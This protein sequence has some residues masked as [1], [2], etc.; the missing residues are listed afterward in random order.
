[1]NQTVSRRAKSKLCYF[2]GTNRG[3]KDNRMIQ[4]MIRSAR[5][6]GV[7]ED[8]YVFSPEPV[9]EAMQSILIKQGYPWK[10]H[11]AKLEFLRRLASETDYDYF[12][13]LDSDN[14]FTRDPGDLANLIRGNPLWVCMEEDVLHPKRRQTDWYGIP[15]PVLVDIF[16][17]EGATCNQVWS[18]NGGFWIVRREAINVV[19][20]RA[21]D[22]FHRMHAAGWKNT[23]DELVLAMLGQTM[24]D[25]PHLNTLKA[26]QDIWACDWIGRFRGTVPGGQPWLYADWLT[27][28]EWKINPAIV[29]AMRSKDAMSGTVARKTQVRPH[30]EPVGTKLSDI[31]KECGVGRPGCGSCTEWIGR[32]NYWGIEGCQKNRQFIL[33]RLRL[34]SKDARWRDWINIAAKGYLSSDALLD[35]ALKRASA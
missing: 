17:R 20:D 28:E 22:F 10:F 6:V 24:V 15:Y 29:H 21:F 19:V 33:D 4:H 16:R 31:L 32:M 3:G 35:E 2:T 27:G 12:A 13:W 14:W 30:R 11:M 8:F 18:S 26:T 7:P 5:A 23:P 25:N 1:M 34:A 9:A